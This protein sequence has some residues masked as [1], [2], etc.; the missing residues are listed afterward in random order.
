MQKFAF[1]K[2]EKLTK[3][4]HIEELFSNGTVINAFPYR[5]LW[6]LTTAQDS[7]IKFAISVPKKKFKR[8]VDRNLLKRRA[9]EA[10]RLHKAE[11]FNKL[12]DENKTLN[13]FFIY[14]SHDILDFHTIE[15]KIV[16]IIQKVIAAVSTK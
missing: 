8:A 3:R 11:L 14:V 7:P 4:K 10:F 2:R 9:R 1:N 5:I 13:I 12:E 15:K 6:E 16:Q